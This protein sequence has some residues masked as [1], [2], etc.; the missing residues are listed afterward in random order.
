MIQAHVGDHFFDPYNNNDC[1][2]EYKVRKIY[3]HTL[4]NNN[5]SYDIGIIELKEPINFGYYDKSYGS[6]GQICLRKMETIVTGQ[7]IFMSLAGWGVID[8]NL[9]RPHL[10]QFDTYKVIDCH[11]L[12]LSQISDYLMESI[13]CTGSDTRFKSDLKGDSGSGLFSIVEAPEADIFNLVGIVNGPAKVYDDFHE[14]NSIF[15]KVGFY[16]D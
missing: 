9:T 12:N 15:A 8:M 16:K 7:S 14:E 11:S 10:L 13:I 5:S 1:S 3:P 4:F 2:I 6:S